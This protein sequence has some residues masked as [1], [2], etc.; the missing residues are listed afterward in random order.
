MNDDRN[1]YRMLED[2][3]LVEL[4]KSVKTSELAVVLGERLKR[5]NRKLDT[6]RYDEAAYRNDYDSQY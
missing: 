3:E 5:A 2:H 1:Y 6:G 4:A